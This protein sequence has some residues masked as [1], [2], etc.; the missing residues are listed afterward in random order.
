M[1]EKIGNVVLDTTFYPGEDYYSDG[2]IEDE[3]L[4]IVREHKPEE[5]PKII[6]QKKSWPIFYHL[7]P[8]RT[9]IIDWLPIKKT[10]KVLEIGSGCGALTGA[11]AAKAGSVTCIDLSKK[12]SLV[13]AFRNIEKDNITIYQIGR[14][15]V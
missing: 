10:D 2:S 9:N 15:H 7:S 6:E 1:T 8:F 11:L 14:A 5:Y 12:R 3:M 13:N 4:D